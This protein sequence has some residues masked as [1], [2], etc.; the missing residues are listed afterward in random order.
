MSSVAPVLELGYAST[1]YSTQGR[2]VD[3][4][5]ALVGIRMTREVLYESATRGRLSNHLYVDVQPEP[6]GPD[7]TH[8]PAEHLDV[9]DLLLT[10]AARRG[11]EVS[12]HRSI[13]CPL[14]V[15]FVRQGPWLLPQGRPFFVRSIVVI[16]GRH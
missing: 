2:T 6:A 16:R 9:R 8:G 4:A 14:E 5:H 12:A 7:V 10:V 15:S 11:S 3:T 13:C 1:A